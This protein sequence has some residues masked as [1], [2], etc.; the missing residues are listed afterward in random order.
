MGA[1]REDEKWCLGKELQVIKDNPKTLSIN[2]ILQISQK[3]V[4]SF[5]WFMRNHGAPQLPNFAAICRDLC[6][7]NK[8]TG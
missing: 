1:P 6:D 7:L 2:F 3:V 8:L 5:G 4:S